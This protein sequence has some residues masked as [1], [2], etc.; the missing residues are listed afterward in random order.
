MKIRPYTEEETDELIKKFKVVAEYCYE[1]NSIAYDILNEKYQEYLLNF[2]RTLFKW[3][4]MTNVQFIQKSYA[5]GYNYITHYDNVNVFSKPLFLRP[6]K[7]FNAGW[8]KEGFNK[9]IFSDAQCTILHAAATIT[10]QFFLS[11]TFSLKYKTLVKYAHR[12]F[13]FDES[14][15]MWLESLEQIYNKAIQWNSNFQNENRTNF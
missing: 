11:D 7:F 5:Y 12:P 15:I 14:D 6:G 1:V 2:K 4:P 3:K 10:D 8:H 9:Y 13:E